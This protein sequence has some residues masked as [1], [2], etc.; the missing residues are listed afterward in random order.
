[1]FNQIA[2]SGRQPS[3]RDGWF[4]PRPEV[5]SRHAISTLGISNRTTGYWPHTLQVGTKWV[6]MSVCSWYTLRKFV[7]RLHVCQDYI[8]DTSHAFDPKQDLKH[9]KYIS[10]W[11]S[12]FSLLFFF[13]VWTHEMYSRV[14]VG[15]RITCAHQFKLGAHFSS[16][17]LR[18]NLLTRSSC[19]WSECRVLISSAIISLNFLNSEDLLRFCG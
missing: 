18:L 10:V 13:A 9:K 15:F 11:W 14:D 2:S 4:V 3:S 6:M 19:Y 16:L 1:M 5:Y 8:S 12:F 7:T 17:H